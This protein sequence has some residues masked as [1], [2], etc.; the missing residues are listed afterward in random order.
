MHPMTAQT[1]ATPEISL[2]EAVWRYRLMSLVIVLAS[3]LA[4]VAATQI[5]FGGATATARFAVTDPTNDNNALGTGVIS[6]QGYATY[7]AQRAVFASSTPVMARAA[8]I[9]KSKNGPDLTGVQ[10]RGRVETSS[11]PDGGVVVVTAS[12]ASVP[13]AAVFANAVVQAYQDVTVSTST[14]K[15][16]EQL[17]KVKEL[18][19]KVTQDMELAQRGSRS[20]KLLADQLGKYQAEE[21]SLL[22]ARS[23]VTAGVQF[24]DTADPAASA[25]SKLPRNTAI[26]LALGAIVACIVSFLRASASHK[27]QARG[28]PVAA[29]GPPPGSGAMDGRQAAVGGPA[30]SMRE[31]PAGR[32]YQGRGQLGEGYADDQHVDQ[33]LAGP[34]FAS[35]TQAVPPRPPAPPADRGRGDRRRSPGMNGS[36]SGSHG[37]RVA[38]GNGAPM[39]GRAAKTPP[40]KTPPAKAPRRGS[41]SKSRGEPAADGEKGPASDIPVD[42]WPETGDPTRTVEDLKYL[43]DDDLAAARPPPAMPAPGKRVSEEP[44]PS[45]EPETGKPEQDGGPAAKTG[46][47]LGAKPGGRSASKPDGGTGKGKGDSSLMH[48]DVDR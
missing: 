27:N 8:E 21:S 38:G 22:S 15:L 42:L 40:A 44:A 9:V 12:G 23:K 46:R 6:G 48:Y 45:A 26:G 37:T 7:T 24:V 34:G 41:H 47:G 2:V 11:K 14:K 19:A 16:N 1:P 10:L 4:S 43:T 31:L 32:S 18:E 29:G 3:V 35:A 20:Y 13:E 39:T 33:P 28:G 17:Q 25:P 5:L 36:G 30:G